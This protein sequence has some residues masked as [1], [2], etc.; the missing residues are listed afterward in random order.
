MNRVKIDRTLRKRIISKKYL[1]GERLPTRIE[2]EK[3][4]DVTPTTIQQALNRLIHD[5]FVVAKGRNGTFVSEQLPHLS[6][7]AIV[8]NRP[9]EKLIEH[10][11]F[12]RSFMNEIK[13]VEMELDV[14]LVLI[15]DIFSWRSVKKVDSLLDDIKEKRVA[16]LIFPNFPFPLIDT[17]IVK[18]D[19][20][21]RVAIS[22]HCIK[23]IPA[24]WHNDEAFMRKT[25]TQ[26]KQ[27]NCKNPAFLVNEGNFIKMNEFIEKYSSENDIQVDS[28]YIQA[29][30]LA[31]KEPL[32]HLVELM[33]SKEQPQ[34]PDSLVITDDSVVELIT[35]KLAAMGFN[36]IDDIKV[37][38]LANFPTLPKSH[39][40]I[41][42]IGYEADKALKL[43]VEMIKDQ[44]VGK[45][46]PK[47]TE[48]PALFE[49]EIKGN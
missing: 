9:L 13:K 19:G 39:L 20:I 26:L 48:L 24:V 15:E 23:N 18:K 25:L 38:T 33:F 8:L 11:H 35:E 28:K 46:V 42:S 27:N 30:S 5:G 37:I 47:L 10:S 31:N 12:Y 14:K 49:H 32:F 16:G 2:L 34:L 6:K 43:C 41:Q 17:D 1:P 36:G 45:E 4:F 7:I 3:E 22:S 40:P 44:I 29:F 21:A